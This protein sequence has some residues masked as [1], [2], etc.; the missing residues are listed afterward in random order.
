MHLY[1]GQAIDCQAQFNRLTPAKRESSTSVY[2]TL[3]ACE[4]LVFGTEKA[5]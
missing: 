5:F 3:I 1:G 4:V 2:A